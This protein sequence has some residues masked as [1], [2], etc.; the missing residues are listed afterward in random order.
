MGCKVEKKECIPGFHQKIRIV[1]LFVTFF[2]GSFSS[3]SQSLNSY[4]DS[5]KNSDTQL[6]KEYY[7][8]KALKKSRDKNNPEGIAMSFYHLGKISQNQ[9]NTTDASNYYTKAVKIAEKNPELLTPKDRALLYKDYANNFLSM[10]SYQNALKY[11]IRTNKI[12][13]E[14]GFREIEMNTTRKMGNVYFYLDD[15]ERSSEYYYQSLSIAREIEDQ[16]GVAFALNNIA[17]NLNSSGNIDEA[18]KIYKKGLKI[19]QQNNIAE[20]IGIFSNNMGDIYMKKGDRESALDHFSMGLSWANKNNDYQ[21]LATYYNNIASVY[22]DKQDYEKAR[23]FFQKSHKYYSKIG[24]KSGL[25]SFYLNYSDL[26]LEAG[27]PDSAKLYL[28]KAE[29]IKNQLSSLSLKSNY[30][31]ILHKY[32][33]KLDSFAQAL[34]YYKEHKKFEDSIM[35]KRTQ[36]KISNLNAVYAEQEHQ[37]Q[38]TELKDKQEELQMYLTLV[39][40]LSFVVISSIIY[41]FVVQ[42]KW[43]RRLKDQNIRFKS[44]QRELAQKNKELN[45]SQKKLEELNK[46]RNQLFSIIS[47][48]LRSPFNSLLGFSEMLIEEVKE[49][50]DYDSIEMM[51]ENIYKS[52]MQLFELIQNLLEWANSERGKIQ[53]K[54]EKIIMRKIAEENVS[55]AK[56]TAQQKGVEIINDINRSITVVADMNMLNTILRNLIFNSVKFTSRNGYVRLFAEDRKNDVKVYIKDNGMG[57]TKEEKERILYSED[58]FSKEGTNKEKGAGLGLILVK[59][60]LKK[61]QGELDIDTTINKGTT[62][63]FTI[64]KNIN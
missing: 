56:H 46:D 40:V 62:F 6:Q 39:G 22:L 18:L 49:G 26:H 1:F 16:R 27:N 7:A 47:H 28:D 48:D 44:Q 59:S 23:E 32:Y 35:S 4:F 14:N 20:A 52:S 50:K 9:G 15:Y 25:A 17:S 61:H 41:A 30:H 13:K 51:T 8:R 2:L 3:M 12:T 53:F 33:I 37:K 29:K 58:T 60:F 10:S 19:A 45:E 57:M 21:A 55:L 5:I 43:N 11:Y 31:E 38:L 34:D 24:N 63:S 64:P 42:R 36:E 54:P